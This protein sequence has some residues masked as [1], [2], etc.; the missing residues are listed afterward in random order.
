M[1]SKVIV[2]LALVLLSGCDGGEPEDIEHAADFAGAA[3][4]VCASHGGIVKNI[5]N[6]FL[7]GY[8]AVEVRC[9]FGFEK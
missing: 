3:R 5:D 7:F 2:V 1:R 9:V 6:D 8:T 4:A